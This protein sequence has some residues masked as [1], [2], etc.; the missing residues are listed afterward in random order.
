MLCFFR[1]VL[2]CFRVGLGFIQ[3]WFQIYLGSVYCSWEKQKSGEAEK[4]TKEAEKQGS[5]EAERYR[6]VKAGKAEKQRSGQAGKSRET[7]K[8][9]TR[10]PKRKTKRKNT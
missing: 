5:K 1:L 9:E 7:E 8:L 6:K 2:A 4:Q 3:G 10:I